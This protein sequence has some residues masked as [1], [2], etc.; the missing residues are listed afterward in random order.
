[1]K[2]L[3]TGGCGFLGSH[4]CE[5]YRKMGE[6]VVSFDNLT[7]HELMRTG[8]D[9][10]GARFYNWNNLKEKGVS[11]IEGDIQ[12]REDLFEVIKDCNYIIHTAAQPAM[13]IA[14]ENPELDLATN[15]VGTF[16]V[17]EAARKY[18]IPVVNCSTIHVYGNKIN[19]TIKEGNTKFIR[20]PPAIDEDHPILQGKLTPLHASKR[21]T[22]IY[23]QTYIDTY[24]LEAATFRLTGMYGPRQFGG[25][26]HGWVANFA[27]RTV[28]NLPIK[29]LGTDKQ[30][31]DILYASDA[32]SAFDAFYKN[33][34]SGLYNIGGG[35]DN[36]I[37]LGECLELLRKIT[38]VEQD[39]R[40]EPARLGDLWYFVC[41]I[42][43]AKEKLKW[44]PKVS[45]EK[46]I[47][48]LVD[49][50]KENIVLFRGEKR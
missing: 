31:R 35:I 6:E 30:V 11:L 9:V 36:I 33:R 4:V 21:T 46:G 13:T 22:E 17:L 18:D 40:F 5:Y 16:N 25:E 42:T 19:E 15:V 45:N 7:K 26:D 41:D 24:G 8:Y 3:V 14:I 47:K 38:G 37:S 32:A 20:E 44:E 2:V 29:I 50:V 1:M 10:E 49:W 27:I 23:V 39:I 48:K 34:K 12:S 28:L 43:K